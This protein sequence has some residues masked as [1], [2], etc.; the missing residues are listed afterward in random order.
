MPLNLWQPDENEDP[1]QA[2]TAGKLDA[3][4]RDAMEMGAARW[5]KRKFP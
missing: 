5:R 1:I 4:V 2:A 3:G